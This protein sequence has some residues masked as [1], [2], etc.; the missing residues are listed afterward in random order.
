[1][2]PTRL[3]SCVAGALALTL[4]A[5]TTIPKTE[6]R[7]Y[8][9]SVIQTREVAQQVLDTWDEASQVIKQRAALKKA[10]EQQNNG[11]PFPTQFSANDTLAAQ[12]KLDAASVRLVALDTVVRYTE[13]LVTLAE[14]RSVEQVQGSAETLRANLISLTGV[15]NIAPIPGLAVA[16][17]LI[18]LFSGAIEKARTQA[19]FRKAVVDGQKAVIAILDFLIEDSNDYYTTVFSLGDPK[20][21]RLR[22]EI[23]SLIGDL[24][25]II[26]NHKKPDDDSILTDAKNRIDAVLD[27]FVPKLVP[28]PLEPGGSRAFSNVAQSQVATILTQMEALN[29]QRVKTVEGVNAYHSLLERYVRLLNSTKSNLLR[30]RAALD[31]EPSAAEIQAAFE[32]TLRLALAA[33][34]EIRIVRD[35]L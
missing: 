31:R 10:R 26:Q 17:P 20:Q 9:E 12:G 29:Q 8:Q 13:V 6:L 18:K 30:L 35:S 7:I 25:K 28:L 21:A 24:V 14:G 4:S 16:G 19:E 1:M 15:L 34:R 22:G 33:R 2:N 11:L 3:V 27:G 5:C 32:Q 23:T